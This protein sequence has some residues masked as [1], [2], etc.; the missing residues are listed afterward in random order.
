MAA[1]IVK[2]DHQAIFRHDT[3]NSPYNRTVLFCN[4]I[5]PCKY[6]TRTPPN[7]CGSHLREKEAFTLKAGTEPP[8]ET[9]CKVGNG[10]LSV[11]QPPEEPLR[12]EAV[13]EPR[14]LIP[15]PGYPSQQD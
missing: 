7:K 2:P 15:C 10:S 13:T 9:V 11:I 5:P 4:T 14:D 12:A 1:A 3:A 8:L 6:C